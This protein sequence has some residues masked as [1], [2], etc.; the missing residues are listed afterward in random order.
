MSLVEALQRVGVGRI[1]AALVDLLAREPDV[2]T[3][4]AVE[5]TDLR[6]PEVSVGMRELVDRGWVECEPIP[7]QGKGRP[8]NRYRLVAEPGRM[9][10]HYEAM[11]QQARSD[12]EAA[13]MSLQRRWGSA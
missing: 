6:Q 8:M 9:H 3:K 5:A 4:E 12:L 2:S 13:M 1:E 11:G 10:V 7:R